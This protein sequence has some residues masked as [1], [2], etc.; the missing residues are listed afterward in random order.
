MADSIESP[1]RGTF[2]P[3]GNDVFGNQDAAPTW[4][5]INTL[6]GAF[7][8]R[9]S[10]PS[11]GYTGHFTQ[12]PEEE[13]IL[14]SPVRKMMIRGYTGHRPK[15]KNLVG[16]PLVPSEEKQLKML[17]EMNTPSV[18]EVKAHDYVQGESFNFRAFAK[19]MDVLERYLW[20]LLKC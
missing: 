4:E 8:K 7:H 2:T 3:V 19:H 17:E 1:E 9:P 12:P 20:R 10:S 18:P 16:E 15:L 14:D 13:H 6:K 11:R 5:G